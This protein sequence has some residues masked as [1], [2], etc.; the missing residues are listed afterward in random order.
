M[1]LQASG[2]ISLADLQTEYGGSNPIGM[3]EYYRGGSLV[4]GSSS[5]T[6]SYTPAYA[7]SSTPNGYFW[8]TDYGFI[9]IRLGTNFGTMDLGAVSSV[10]NNQSYSITANSVIDPNPDPANAGAHM[11]RLT[12]GTY[13]MS[14]I[15]QVSF[16]D[17][18]GEDFVVNR[19]GGVQFTCCG[20]G[21]YHGMSHTIATL[22]NKNTGVP[23]SGTVTLSNF[24]SGAA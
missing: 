17:S 21:N 1:A 18:G 7:A 23:A 13:N 19:V 6:T 4:A 11:L 24:Y 3:N 9:E 12:S 5:S 16:T 10:S 14:N 22:V 8:R 15:T 20:L 2:Q